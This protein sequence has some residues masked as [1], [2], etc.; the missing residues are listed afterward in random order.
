MLRHIWDTDDQPEILASIVNGAIESATEVEPEQTHIQS[1][2]TEAPDANQLARD[3]QRI[4][5]ALNQ[6][7]LNDTERS[8][9]RDRVG[10]LSGR[11]EWVAD[12]QQR[13]HLEQE[14]QNLW[15]KLGAQP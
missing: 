11:C 8:Y 7:D 1:R 14:V 15:D 2:K 6:Q 10:L 5:A 13:K 12:D 4:D 3:L 9:L